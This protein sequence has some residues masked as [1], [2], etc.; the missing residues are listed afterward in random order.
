[1]KKINAFTSTLNLSCH[2]YSSVKL[3][4]GCWKAVS[5]TEEEQKEGDGEGRQSSGRVRNVR[6]VDEEANSG[7]PAGS[8]RRWRDWRLETRETQMVW[9]PE[10][11]SWQGHPCTDGNALFCAVHGGGQQ[12]HVDFEKLNF[13]YF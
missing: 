5:G 12:L 11:H 1:M 4:T 6:N 8:L 13:N 3:T 7:H 2:P 9:V 10:Q